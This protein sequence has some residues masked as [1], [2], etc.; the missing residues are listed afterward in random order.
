MEN[1]R[2]AIKKIVLTAPI[3]LHPRNTFEAGKTSPVK[4]KLIWNKVVG[5]E[6]YEI[7]VKRL[8]GKE[9]IHKLNSETNQAMIELEGIY[10]PPY[11]KYT[12]KVRVVNGKTKSDWSKSETFKVTTK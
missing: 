6:K 5:A 10:K 1:E 11:V 12:W 2:V 3:N 9:K 8:T 4:V 7:E